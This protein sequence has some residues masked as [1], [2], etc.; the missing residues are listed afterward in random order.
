MDT[1]LLNQLKGLDLTTEKDRTKAL[2]ITIYY[3]L[4]KIER[5]LRGLG[6]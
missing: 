6:R 4:N 3:S 5:A 1:E 2:C